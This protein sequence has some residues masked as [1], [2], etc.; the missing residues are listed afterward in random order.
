[1]CSMLT[2]SDGD[3]VGMVVKIGIRIVGSYDPTIPHFE[4]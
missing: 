4:K 2:L 3:G 1:M